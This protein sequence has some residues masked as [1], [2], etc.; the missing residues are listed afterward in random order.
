MKKPIVLFVELKIASKNKYV[1]DIAEKLFD[2]N[3]SVSIFTNELKSAN[4]LNDLLWTWKQDSF[5]PHSIS[6]AEN[7]SSDPVSIS[8]SIDL[9]PQ[10]EALILFD[11][12]PLNELEKF[13]LVF[14]FAE[15][16]HS[17]K[18][19]ESRQRFKQMRDSEKFDLH[20]TQLG[21]ILAKKTIS[22]EQVN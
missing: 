18:K 7:G 1:C 5:I 11:P 10:T 2:N 14:D 21:A 13:K 20:F 19:Q 4:Q 6:T 8:S 15:V 12:L 17:E 16:Y 22:L 9:I 3:I